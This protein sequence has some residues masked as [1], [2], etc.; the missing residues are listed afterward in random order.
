M[1]MQYHAH[2]KVEQICYE[3]DQGLSSSP[4][5]VTGPIWSCLEREARNPTPQPLLDWQGQTQFSKWPVCYC[6]SPKQRR[7]GCCSGFC[8]AMGDDHTL[9]ALPFLLLFMREMLWFAGLCGLP[10]V[11][12]QFWV[13]KGHNSWAQRPGEERCLLVS[14][15]VSGN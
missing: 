15:A 7:S 2:L 3:E 11:T 5:S 12:F 8:S 9:P 6:D 10:S 14:E 1:F 13:R 4:E